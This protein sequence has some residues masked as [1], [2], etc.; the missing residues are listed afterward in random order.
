[1]R[2]VT[3]SWFKPTMPEGTE[4]SNKWNRK[5]KRPTLAQPPS[6]RHSRK[7]QAEADAAEIVQAE[8]DYRAEQLTFSEL[9]MFCQ[10]FKPEVTVDDVIGA[11]G[12]HYRGE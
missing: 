5:H 12:R 11:L 4:P 9:F 6:D 3:A 1:M 7:L 10:S 2:Y 8:L